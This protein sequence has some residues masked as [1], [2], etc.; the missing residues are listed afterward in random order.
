MENNKP[1]RECLENML[2]IF[3]DEIQ[4]KHDDKQT[5]YIKHIKEAYGI[6][7]EKYKALTGYFYKRKI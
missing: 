2:N 7:Q 1:M 5:K 3:Y 6:Y 4:Q